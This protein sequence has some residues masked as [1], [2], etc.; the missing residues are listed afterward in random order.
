MIAPRPK[1]DP[2]LR[3]HK[4]SGRGFVELNGRRIYLGRWGDP[5]T[6]ERY[7]KVIVPSEV[8][9][10]LQAVGG[11]KRGRSAAAG[12]GAGEARPRGRHRG[13]PPAREPAG[14]AAG[15]AAAAHRGPPGRTRV[16]LRADSV[17]ALTG[18]QSQEATLPEPIRAGILAMVK[19]AAK[20]NTR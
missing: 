12:D 8:Y 2:K 15:R 3:H 5:E 14:L 9:N 4:A 18:R 20:D 11:L 6:Q 10:G 17:Q 16:H 7:H 19:A 1:P 13:D